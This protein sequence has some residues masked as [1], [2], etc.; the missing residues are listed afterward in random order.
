MEEQAQPLTETEIR[1]KALE[2]E[3]LPT[4]NELKQMMLDIRALLME[5]ASPL[6]SQNETRTSSQND[7]SKR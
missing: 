3:L 6:R 1:I 2:D 4:K 5:A 7:R